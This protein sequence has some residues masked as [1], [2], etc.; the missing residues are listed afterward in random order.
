[1]TNIFSV[2][3]FSFPYQYKFPGQATDEKIMYV[4]RENK[5][6]LYLRL[7]AVGVVSLV[8]LLTGLFLKQIIADLFG[9]VL[10]GM[11][12]LV[13]VGLAGACL[14]LGSWWMYS[15][16]RKSI[17]IVTNK[18]LT[19]F[20]YSTPVSRHSLSLPLDMIVDTGAYTKGFIQTFL[21]LG[22]FTAR[23]SAASSGVATDDNA[24]VNKKYF[25]IN[26]VKRAEDLQ[27]YVSKLLAAFHKYPDK[28]EK[29]RP[30]IPE[31]KGEARAKFIQENYPEYWS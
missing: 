8:L 20:I 22:T 25:Y 7:A 15:L 27:H 5:L 19:K 21:R 1:M 13:V 17:A 6:L 16:W 11:F 28:L 31:L 23:S 24:R 26:N 10:G 2:S 12:E 29:F 30:F 3:Q 14:L 9:F 4:T 18:R